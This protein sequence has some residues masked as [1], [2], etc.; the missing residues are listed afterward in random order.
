M[1]L[2]AYLQI[3]PSFTPSGKLKG[4]FAKKVTTRHPTKPLAG[5][6]TLKL[7]ITIPDAAFK[8]VQVDVDVP[9]ECLEPSAQVRIAEN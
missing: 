9:L 4:V 8:P 6:V 1:K 5:A 7:N 3:Q 2:V